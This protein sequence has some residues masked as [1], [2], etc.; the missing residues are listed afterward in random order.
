MHRAITIRCLQYLSV[1][2]ATSMITET[3]VMPAKF[4]V[5]ILFNSD[6]AALKSALC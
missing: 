4:F 6:N 5:Y 3:S 1:V 2:I